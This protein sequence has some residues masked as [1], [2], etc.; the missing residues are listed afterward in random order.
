MPQEI[1]SAPALPVVAAFDFDGTLTYR[2]TLIPFLARVSLCKLL[3]GLTL[4]SP[5]LALLMCGKRGNDHGMA[6]RQSAKQRLCRVVL[7][8]RRQADLKELAARW[9]PGIALRPDMLARL[10]THQQSGH[11]VVIVSASPDLYLG[12][13]ARRLGV[14][15]ICTGL[16]TADGRL[17]GRFS[18][19][20][21]WGPEKVARLEL[22]FGPVGRYELHAYGDSSGDA[23]LLNA[24]D[25]AWLNGRKVVR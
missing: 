24:A 13:M 9:V 25:C 20:N 7:R 19:A 21:C 14:E 12:E 16:E 22:R 3:L 17:T 11:R 1:S 23:W 15:L 8:G 4:V 10:R 2:D 5:V 18:T 6:L